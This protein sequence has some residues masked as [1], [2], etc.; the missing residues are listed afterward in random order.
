MARHTHIHL[1]V[2]TADGGEFKESDHP[3]EPDGKFGTGSG[4]TS[5]VGQHTPEELK[6]ISSYKSGAAA[7]LNSKIRRGAALSKEEQQVKELFDQKISEAPSLKEEKAMHYGVEPVT[8]FGAFLLDPETKEFTDP[9]FVPMSQKENVANRFTSAGAGQ[10][11]TPK[12]VKLVKSNGLVIHVNMPIGSKLL[13]VE[14]EPGGLKKESEFLTNRDQTFEIIK[15]EKRQGK[16][17]LVDHITVQPKKKATQTQDA[18]VTAEDYEQLADELLAFIASK[19]SATDGEWKEDLHPRADNGQFGSGGGGAAQKPAGG[20]LGPKPTKATSTVAKH[21]VHELLSSGHPWTI[22]ELA[23]A[24]GH[25]NK[26]SLSSWLSMF[27]NAKTA[28]PKGTLNIVKLP[29][30]Q[31]QV[32]KSDG[33]PAPKVDVP[34]PPVEKKPKPVAAS[35]PVAPPPPPPAPVATMG[36]S[37]V[38]LPKV[39]SGVSADDFGGIGGTP[40]KFGQGIKDLRQAMQ[41]DVNIATEAPKI[42][43]E[44]EAGLKKELANSKAFQAFKEVAAKF[45]GNS[46]PERALISNWASSSGDSNYVSCA[47]QLA[48]RDAFNLKGTEVGGMSLLQ[49]PLAEMVPAMEVAVWREAAKSFGYKMDTPERIAIFKEALGDFAKAQYNQTQEWFKKRGITEVS[50]VRGMRTKPPASPEQ[51]SMG[52]Q[53]ASSFSAD[54]STSSKFAGV[55]KGTMLAA[56]IPV[57]HVLSTYRTGYGCAK[58]HEVVVLGDRSLTAVAAPVEFASSIPFLAAAGRRAFAEKKTPVTA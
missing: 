8:P 12:G 16:Y 38:T 35:K 39:V 5:K 13:K 20:G 10:V 28:G 37:R 11:N 48:I 57:S 19:G 25:T 21:A 30:G 44:V 1:H 41:A 51:V 24:T 54:V 3:R 31:Y 58:E 50:V 6:L 56:K 52:L 47:M 22:E 53:P 42:K 40:S 17:G 55:T 23:T 45:G 4:G 9:G 36:S 14:D 2:G 49:A 15:R 34:K 43:A 29:G 32:V 18:E 27:K 26:T 33:Q 46:S 7:S